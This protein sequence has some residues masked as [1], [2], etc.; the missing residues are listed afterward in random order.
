MELDKV[1]RWII[2][3]GFPSGTP[4]LYLSFK[5]MRC[6]IEQTEE[7]RIE[8]CTNTT[9]V[10]AHLSIYV[11][12]FVITA[13]MVVVRPGNDEARRFWLERFAT[14]NLSNKEKIEVIFTAIAIACGLFLFSNIN[15]RTGDIQYFYVVGSLGS[16]SV[17]TVLYIESKSTLTQL[18]KYIEG[19]DDKEGGDGVGLGKSER[20]KPVVTELSLWFNSAALGL[21]GA[22]NFFFIIFAIND[23]QRMP[24]FGST[25]AAIAASSY[26]FSILFQPRKSSRTYFAGMVLFFLFA[27]VPGEIAPAIHSL[28]SGSEVKGFTVSVLPYIRILV[29][30]TPMF[31]LILKLRRYV[32]RLDDEELGIYLCHYVLRRWYATLIPMLF[33]SFETM[34]CIFEDGGVS[35]EHCGQSSCASMFLSVNI[36]LLNVFSLVQKSA[37]KRVQ[38]DVQVSLS[39]VASLRFT[40]LRKLQ[41][42]L[43]LYAALTSLYL[44]SQLGA[45]GKFNDQLFIIGFSGS[46]GLSIIVFLESASVVASNRRHTV[47]RELGE[48][49]GQLFSKSTGKFRAESNGCNEDEGEKEDEDK[50][51][52]PRLSEFFKADAGGILGEIM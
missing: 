13:F 15:N 21:V 34:A 35:V 36:L 6:F 48:I 25:F 19:E 43:L 1:Y 27:V 44:L 14:L 5:G 33:L 16:V 17:G 3:V 39:E 40:T 20:E 31:W 51:G 50:G 29:A 10:V 45:R 37:S 52:S 47:E 12:G 28:K 42:L 7:G 22:V 41:G 30:Y 11:V 49:K 9:L 24:V 26:L 2:T 18:T 38:V 4:L 32:S 46:L 8:Q 23:D